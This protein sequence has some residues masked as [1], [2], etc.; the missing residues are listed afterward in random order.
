MKSNEGGILVCENSRA[1]TRF[2]RIKVYDY[3]LFCDRNN[4]SSTDLKGINMSLFK[5]LLMINTNYMS[6]GDVEISGH[7]LRVLPDFAV[8][9]SL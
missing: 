5:T 2:R 8:A 7:R 1:I 4:V 9:C 6:N 3:Q